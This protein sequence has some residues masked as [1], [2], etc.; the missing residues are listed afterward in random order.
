[1]QPKSFLKTLKFIHTSFL[2]GLVIVTFF[3]FWQQNSFI[4]EM[5]ADDFLIYA[6]PVLAAIGYFVSQWLFQKMV[7]GIGKEEPI[8]NK[9]GAY[10]TASII[11][12]ALI[13]GPALFA[14]A[15]YYLNGNALH[16]VIGI[17][18]VFYLFRQRPSRQKI[19]TALPLTREEKMGLFG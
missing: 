8:S 19:E 9:L 5:D 17:F 2:I 6:V 4:A 15:A 3:A 14:S 11:K 10:R 13:E 18:M 7:K 12:Y 16:L 1:M